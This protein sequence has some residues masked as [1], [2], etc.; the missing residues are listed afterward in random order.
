MNEIK[1]LKQEL[2]LRYHSCFYSKDEKSSV[3]VAYLD[4]NLQQINFNANG[5][6]SLKF[7]SRKVLKQNTRFML[8]F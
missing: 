2:A 8:I 3:F 4:T 1:H 7:L 5:Q 6:K